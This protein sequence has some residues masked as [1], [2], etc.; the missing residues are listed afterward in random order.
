MF[1][2][3]LSR[4]SRFTSAVC[5]LYW[6]SAYN[7]ESIDQAARDQ[8]SGVISEVLLWLANE[9]ER[10]QGKRVAG[11]GVSQLHGHG[12]RPPRARDLQ[13][14]RLRPLRDARY[15]AH[16]A[17]L[18]ELAERAQRDELEAEDFEY[19]DLIAESLEVRV[20]YRPDEHFAGARVGNPRPSHSP[21]TASGL[22]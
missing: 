9:A 8:A 2:E 10:Q 7:D 13:G 14:T 15:A 1:Q 19:L 17:R 20:A 18:R 21:G 16:P 3:D 4:L 12:G 22:G 5:D 11:M 6:S